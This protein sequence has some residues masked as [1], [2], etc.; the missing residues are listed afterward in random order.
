[1]INELNDTLDL[2]FSRESIDF[3]QL[4]ILRFKTGTGPTIVIVTINLLCCYLA[5]SSESL[6]SF[7]DHL[8]KLLPLVTITNVSLQNGFNLT[9]NLLMSFNSNLLPYLGRQLFQHVFF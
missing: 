9:D 5:A 2:C 3:R 7:L 6:V 8:F 4:L 1:M